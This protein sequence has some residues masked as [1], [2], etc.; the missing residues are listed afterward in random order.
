[1]TTRL[2]GRTAELT[3]VERDDTSRSV[4]G[5]RL[6]GSGAVLV[7]ELGDARGRAPFDL[8]CAF[9]VLEHIEQDVAAL[10]EWA[11]LLAPGGH[12]LVSVPA[13]QHLFGP[14][15]EAAGHIR[16]YA[17][18]ELEGRLR[19]AGLEPCWVSGYGW[20]VGHLLEWGKGKLVGWTGRA[21]NGSVDD[22]TAQS[23]RWLQPRTGVSGKLRGLCALPFRATQRLAPNRGTG[24]VALA[25]RSS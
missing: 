19:E 15:D 24:L 10:R 2:V 16:R 7:A 6:Q 8:V 21:G 22:R 4:A 18:E 13:W 9:E 17:P 12:L 1:M 25:R 20:P 14:A 23:G 3:A 5:S 11:S